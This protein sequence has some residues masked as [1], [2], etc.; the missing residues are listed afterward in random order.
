MSIEFRVALLTLALTAGGSGF[1]FAQEQLPS[2]R[3]VAVSSTNDVRL[4][5]R[6]KVALRVE[7]TTGVNQ[8]VRVMN[9]SWY[10]EWVCSNTNV[11]P[12]PWACTRNFPVDVTI[13]PGGAYT[14]QMEMQIGPPFQAEHVTFRMGFTPIGSTSTFWSDDLTL[15]IVRPP[16]WSRGAG[17]DGDNWRIAALDSSIKFDG[18]LEDQISSVLRECE[19]IQPGMTRA[20]LLELFTTEGGLSTARHRTYVFRRC[21]YVKVNVDFDP[22]KPDQYVLDEEMTDTISKI[23]KPYLDWAIID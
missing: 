11:V 13:P 9:C 10:D 7:N 17:N 3:V 16:N 8:T 15:K 22:S 23:S 2:L 20:Q 21:S 1:T 5:E 18:Q 12:L 6:F 4:N 19:K 14:N